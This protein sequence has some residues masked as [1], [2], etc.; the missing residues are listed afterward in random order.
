MWLPLLAAMLTLGRRRSVEEQTWMPLPCRNATHEQGEQ[1]LEVDVRLIP[2]KT[3]KRERRSEVMTRF[4]QRRG[5]ATDCVVEKI[6][7]AK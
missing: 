3:R 1:L 2:A 7:K 4:Q 5:L 6:R